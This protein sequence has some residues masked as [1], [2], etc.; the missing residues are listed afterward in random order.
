MSPE[1]LNAILISNEFS[2]LKDN[3]I[4]CQYET[5]ACG[6]NKLAAD[7]ERLTHFLDEKCYCLNLVMLV[8][9]ET[10]CELNRAVISALS[11]LIEI[12]KNKFS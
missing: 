1:K 3:I 8:Y 12:E 10:Y 7:V 6:T 11:C 2:E 4:S 5:N 9:K